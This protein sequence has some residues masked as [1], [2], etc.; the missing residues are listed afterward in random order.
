ME[1]NKKCAHTHTKDRNPNQ[2][3]TEKQY[4][5]KNT[6]RTDGIGRRLA[7]KILEISRPPRTPSLSSALLIPA[8]LV[9]ALYRTSGL[10]V[11]HSSCP[12]SIGTPPTASRAELSQREEGRKKR[13][14]S[15]EKNTHQQPQAKH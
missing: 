2:R 10:L 11:S 8:G 9:R 3:V 13:E 4:G 14:N 6:W 15:R 5:V 12:T 7:K 1:E